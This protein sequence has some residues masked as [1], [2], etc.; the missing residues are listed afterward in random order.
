[1]AV[2]VEGANLDGKPMTLLAFLLAGNLAIAAAFSLVA[3][4]TD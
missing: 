2:G 4:V 3:V 1:V